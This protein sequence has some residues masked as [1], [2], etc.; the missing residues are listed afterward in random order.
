MRRGPSSSRRLLV[1]ALACLLAVANLGLI[2]YGVAV[3]RA[4]DPTPASSAHPGGHI[5]SL[6]ASDDDGEACDN[7]GSGSCEDEDEDDDDSGRG[8][9][10]GRGRGGDD[11]EEAAGVAADA[12]TGD[13]LEVRIVG[14]SFTPS[15]LTVE[16]GQTV[17][18][19]NTDDDE[20]TATGPEFDTGTIAPG[21]SATVT[22][23]TAGSFDYVCSFHPEMRGTIVVT[24]AGAAAAGAATPPATPG[25]TPAATPG[26]TPAATPGGSPIALTP[27]GSSE[28]AEQSEQAVE[29]VDFAFTPESITVVLG[30]TVVW[31]NT[32]QAPHTVSGDFA[33]SGTLEPG[34][35]FSF[36]FTEP[37]TYGYICAFHPNMVGE[38]VVS[39]GG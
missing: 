31:T 32:G 7:S 39:N 4:P 15:T 29:I 30:T 1:V 33:D 16:A 12:T 26:A 25:A 38:V 37:G 13:P 28:E 27:V 21:G 34:Q 9:G 22:L 8:R 18:F 17:T 3:S 19:I 20:H 2:A 36:T 23:D 11:D 35:T 10:R 5:A 6:R 14:R 24:E